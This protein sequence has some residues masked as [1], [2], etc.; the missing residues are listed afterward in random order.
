MQWRLFPLYYYVITG[1]R[2]LGLGPGPRALVGTRVPLGNGLK[3][4][5][6]IVLMTRTKNRVPRIHKFYAKVWC[7]INRT[8]HKLWLWLY[9]RLWQILISYCKF[10]MPKPLKWDMLSLSISIFHWDIP[11]NEWKD[12]KIFLHEFTSFDNF[13]CLEFLGFGVLCHNFWT[14]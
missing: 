7:T 6:S 3:W 5:D 13:A 14:N 1:R 11:K 10:I 12:L 2:G 9:Y 4:S 8:T